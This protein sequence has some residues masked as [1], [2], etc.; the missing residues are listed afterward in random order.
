MP[1]SIPFH[2]GLVL[3]NIIQADHT[4][5]LEN[6]TKEKN[7]IDSSQ[8]KHNLYIQQKHKLDMVYQE[9]LSIGVP[10]GELTKLENEIENV[11]KEI[12]QSA[13]EYSETV[14]NSEAKIAELKSNV[15]SSVKQEKGLIASQLSNV[16]SPLDWTK[17]ELKSVDLSFDSMELDCQFFDCKFNNFDAHVEQISQYI[18]EKSMDTLGKDAA[19]NL[20]THTLRKLKGKTPN[21][22]L[23][24]TLVLTANCT[25]KKANT[26][27]TLNLDGYKAIRAWNTLYPEDALDT[28]D[29]DSVYKIAQGQDNSSNTLRVLT[30]VTFGSSFVGM[31]HLSKESGAKINLTNESGIEQEPQPKSNSDHSGAQDKTD[32]SQDP[33]L[34]N[35]STLQ[36]HC[37]VVTMGV[38]PKLTQS[39][40][41]TL[42]KS[43]IDNPKHI[44]N[45]IDA[46]KIRTSSEQSTTSSKNNESKELNQLLNLSQRNLKFALSSLCDLEQ[47]HSLLDTNALIRMFDNYTHS[48]KEFTGGVPLNLYSTSFSKAD[49][50][51][52]WL[53]N[54]ASQNSRQPPLQKKA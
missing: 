18:H 27:H 19:N 26:F 48:A 15:L 6:L 35:Q 30:T 12:L 36:S 50:A 28:S 20:K 47:T 16:E 53:A 39:T 40:S 1:T 23:E 54:N 5:Y 24:G 46:V 21:H 32:N 4:Q 7:K 2:P 11:N 31:V 9:L 43:T 42:L 34:H 29:I 37:S 13:I 14:R 38:I 10:Q 45:Q 51:S 25:H 52:A 8:Q 41:D 22:K 3:G 33:L 49:V 17:C 44:L